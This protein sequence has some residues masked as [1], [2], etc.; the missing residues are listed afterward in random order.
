MTSS[1]YNLM[2]TSTATYADLGWAWA[3]AIW[4]V[5]LLG[6]A[7]AALAV[8]YLIALIRLGNPLTALQRT[9][10]GLW[11]GVVGIGSSL[12]HFGR[13][14]AIAKLTF[15]EAVR[16]RVLYVFVLFAVPLL[17]LGWYLPNS[18]EGELVFYAAFISASI[19]YLLFP[20]AI[21]LACSSLPADIERKTIYT[22]V[23]KPVRKLE[24]VLGKTL[25]FVGIFTLVLA[26]MGLSS[27]AYLYFQVS[28]YALANQWTARVPIYGAVVADT[29]EGES[30][31]FPRLTFMTRG[32]ANVRGINVGN[33]WQYRSHIAG[34][35]ADRAIWQFRFEPGFI[36]DM[37]ARRDQLR[38]QIDELRGAGALAE[39]DPALLDQADTAV[40]L[41]GD[42]WLARAADATALEGGLAADDL[43]RLRPVAAEVARLSAL[44]ERL[45]GLTVPV[46]FTFHIFKTT[47]GDPSRRN[48]QE[49]GVW[50][51]MT[52]TDVSGLE[53]MDPTQD[54]S[55][56]G[57]ASGVKRFRVENNRLNTLTGY[58]LE[59]FENGMVRAEVQCLSRTQY[60]GM[61]AGDLWL[62]AAENSYAW[63]F[64][65][66]LFTLWLQLLL[67]T[68]VAVAASTVLKGYVALM[69]T[70]LVYVLG[71]NFE[72]IQGLVRGQLDGGGPFEALVRLTIQTNT[73]SPL[74]DNFVYRGLKVVDQGL[75]WLLDIL[76]SRIVPNLT[77]LDTTELLARGMNIPGELVL[78]NALIVLGY[79]VPIL[80]LGYF[81][82]RERELAA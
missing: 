55:G 5:Q 81:M 17:F 59:I 63:N 39:L 53:N 78:R 47:K 3:L 36:E 58:P 48:A 27:L 21:Y 15:K 33:E 66:W 9:L 71:R 4:A 69:L 50:G 79:V 1:S 25:G 16:R 44:R 46:Q 31:V 42:D 62:L 10:A 57:R 13:T 34:G 41:Y 30:R 60:L 52:L 54:V 12:R 82:L 73:Q 68:S 20:L 29:F 7:V 43:Q 51:Q 24:V 14:W 45:D 64:V 72:F 74:E 70:T 11:D 18:A 8:A 32:K 35:T 76:S 19:E 67:L 56:Q 6:V 37:I 2:Y 80:L 26:V 28:D 75:L 23:T 65:K 40:R 61:A 22:I 38:G 49:A 77:A